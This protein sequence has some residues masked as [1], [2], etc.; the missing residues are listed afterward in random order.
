MQNPITIETQIQSC[1][2]KH[3][4]RNGKYLPTEIGYNSIISRSTCQTADK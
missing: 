4:Y 3:E 2:E 1:I